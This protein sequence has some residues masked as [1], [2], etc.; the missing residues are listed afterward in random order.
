[1]KYHDGSFPEVDSVSVEGK[2][3]CLAHMNNKDLVKYHDGS[4]PEVDSVS[5]E[6]KRDC[7]A[8]VNNTNPSSNKR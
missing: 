5:L 4:F 8:H 2:R 3:D 1:V 7:L 6:G